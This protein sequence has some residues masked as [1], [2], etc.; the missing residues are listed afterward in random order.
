MD[1]DMDVE[2]S[3]DIM[4]LVRRLATMN[5]SGFKNTRTEP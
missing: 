4:D 2:Y 5:S 1:I 3:G